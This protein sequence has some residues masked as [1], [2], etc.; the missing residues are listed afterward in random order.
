MQK[1]NHE[2]DE[3]PVYTHQHPKQDFQVERIAF[4]SDAI[5]AIAI[6]LLVIEFKIPQ[7]TKDST[8]AQ[9]LHEVAEL[10]YKFF[11]LILSFALITNYW[12]RH[13]L[14]FKHLHNYN[15]QI[16]LANMISL[17]PMI[18]FPFTTAFF[19]ESS[20]YKDII[21]IPFR[22]F[23]LNNIL[24]GATSYFLYLTIMKRF[25][26]MVYPM[27]KSDEKEFRLKLLMMTISF[28]LVY[29]F[30]YLMY[31]EYTFIGLLPILIVNLYDKY[32]KKKTQ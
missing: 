10:K 9:V 17:L 3:K 25:N 23:I 13:H 32:F 31:I 30:S 16:V 8:Y 29:I 2:Q 24:A 1:K 15:R 6:T 19:Y 27:E 22:L 28:I 21:I 12:M 4:F 7:I 14:L 26:K 11:A 5:F 20:N 18:F